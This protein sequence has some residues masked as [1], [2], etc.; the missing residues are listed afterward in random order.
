M[1]GW[2]LLCLSLCLAFTSGCSAEK[3]GDRPALRSTLNPCKVPATEVDALCGSY[4]VWE[5]R[6]ARSGRKISLSLILIPA[7]DANP[8]PDPFF[9]FEGGP[10]V[11]ATRTAGLLAEALSAIHQTRD[12][13]AI[14]QR[15]AGGPD[16]LDCD[17]SGVHPAI[18]GIGIEGLLASPEA[19]KECR[20]TLRKNYD[21]SRYTTAA[22]ADDVNEIR[23]ALGY[24]KINVFGMS[25]GTRLAAVYL[26]RHP[27]SV[28]TVTVLGPA[29]PPFV[30]TLHFARD[31]QRALN[32]LFDDCKADPACQRAFPGLEGDLQRALDRLPSYRGPDTGAAS[33]SPAPENPALT[34]EFFATS[35][36]LMLYLADTQARIPQLV[37]AMA[38][39]NDALYLESLK[40]RRGFP[41][42][43]GDGLFLSIV[44]TEDAV[45][46]TPEE[47]R[48]TT[49]G[50]FLGDFRATITANACRDWPVGE[51]P[52][53]FHD[54]VQSDVPI[55][56]LTGELD[57]VTPPAQARASAAHFP[58]SLLIVA[59]KSA[60]FGDPRCLDSIF[61]P[62]VET[63]S[64]KNL[65][66]SCVEEITRPAFVL[67]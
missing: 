12:I 61:Q 3:N 47:I 66:T 15:G 25:Y 24:K 67:P 38:E 13:V 33:P 9:F 63:G 45:R 19:V 55:L 31:A 1:R 23:E 34:R 32:L 50:T 6:D 30:H 42:G 21:L 62:F 53:G 14:D 44:C 22:T 36:R 43:A 37:H 64:V 35:I 16:A 52:P 28:R 48:R 59:P 58:N 11:P 5:N 7:V 8:E 17:M 10:G 27:E 41:P 46:F 2:L 18:R 65:D 39:G 49:R 40:E 26:R 60:H 56:F 4:Q 54:P 51:V 20:E 29:L 57:P